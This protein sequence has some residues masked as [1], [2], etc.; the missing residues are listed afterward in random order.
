MS[1][2]N[3]LFALLLIACLQTLTFAAG[4]ERLL[5]NGKV[6]T[7]DPEHPYAEAVAIRDDQIVAVGSR[8]EASQAVGPEAETVDL[9]GNFLTPGLID[10]H[11][12]AV[13]GGL[14][15]IS[16]NIGE[17]V[18]YVDQLVTFVAD[19]KKSGRGMR[20]DILEI[21]GIP[22]A[23]WSRNSELNQRLNTG[24]Y[25]GQP[26]LLKGMDGH[27]AWANQAMLKRAGINQQLIA[28]LDTVGRGYYGFGPDFE[29]NGF[30]V[31][32]GVDRAAAVI[33]QP[34]PE[35]ML[36]AGRA[37]VEYLHALGITAWLDPAVTEEYLQAYRQLAERGELHSHV[38]AIPVIDFES[39]HPEQQLATALKLRGD[40]KNVPEVKVVGIKVYADGVVEYPSQTAVL[41]KPYHPS[42]KNGEMKN[43]EIKN[44]ELLFDPAQ[45]AKI[46]IAA[47]QQGMIVHV[48]A[49]GDQAVTEALNGIAAARKANG[50]SGLPHTVTHLRFI[51]PKDIP[52][53]HEL[54]VIASFQLYW[55]SAGTDTIEL[56]KP[57]VDPAIYAWQYPARSVLNTGGIIAGSSDWPVS[58]ANVFQA[59]YQAETR[60]GPA[61]VLDA[62]QR[63]PRE[64]MLYAYTINSA[65]ALGEQ[66]TI[67]SIT[68]GKQA[69]FALLDRDV[70]TVTA[71]EARDAKVLWTIVGGK[72]VYGAKP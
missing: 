22:L 61:G 64:A 50:N 3:R 29:P 49:I 69:D 6:F 26:V 19:A 10:S 23:F 2:P 59:I 17:N 11:C 25:A 47:D 7:A 43:G 20:G 58:T 15:L 52:R 33:P 14:T 32:A 55:A 71:E 51:R 24:P 8:T 37:A 9:K 65:R 1:R 72:T 35:R 39:G 54:G 60:K 30:L 56:V 40:F 45:F 18:R 67:G 66:S 46:A 12:H 4:Q 21:S 57:Y 31:D 53:F 42:G 34:S 36:A 16:A 44:G 70:L 68:P 13:E 48:H 38:R 63:V 5:Y 62:S 28:G 41:S 27:T